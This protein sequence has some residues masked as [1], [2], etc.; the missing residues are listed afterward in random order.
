MRSCAYSEC[1]KEFK[2]KAHNQKYC[3]IECCKIAT[4]ARLMD[5]YYARRARLS[6]AKRMCAGKKCNVRLSRYNDGK[7][8]SGCSSAGTAEKKQQLLEIAR[9]AYGFKEE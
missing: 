3:S 5:Q 9:Q 1:T 7:L 2:A 6:G 4:N 8:C